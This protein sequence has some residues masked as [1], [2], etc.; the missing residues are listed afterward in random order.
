MTY[1]LNF[2]KK[3]S[4]PEKFRVERE[5]MN[6]LPVNIFSKAAL[7]QWLCL[8][9][10]KGPKRHMIGIVINYAIY[11]Q[12]L[13]SLVIFCLTLTKKS[14]KNSQYFALQTGWYVFFFEWH[15][16]SINDIINKIINNIDNIDDIMNDIEQLCQLAYLLKIYWSRL[17]TPSYEN[18]GS[19]ARNGWPKIKC[20]HLNFWF[21]L[22][23][24][25]G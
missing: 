3:K 15:L 17:S 23:N 22:S 12:F 16:E 2:L 8:C 19:V 11:K 10:G 18:P 21:H 14:H 1:V 7:E 5:R 24:L 4:S 6:I 9:H 25:V 20:Y 13:C